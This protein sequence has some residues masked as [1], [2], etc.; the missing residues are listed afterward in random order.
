MTVTDEEIAR[1]QAL[2]RAAAAANRRIGSCPYP[3][4]ENV[5]RL[6]W[7]LA[8]VDAGGRAGVEGRAARV[9]ARLERWRRGT[10]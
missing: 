1:A 4:G 5:L 9:A 8:Y 10:P 2:G 6:R 3:R 7:V